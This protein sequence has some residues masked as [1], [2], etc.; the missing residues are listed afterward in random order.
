MAY[1]YDAIV[2]QLTL[3]VFKKK[4]LSIYLTLHMF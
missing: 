4:H 3:A 1:S 2:A